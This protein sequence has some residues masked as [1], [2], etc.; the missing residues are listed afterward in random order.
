MALMTQLPRLRW[1]HLAA[2]AASNAAPMPVRPAG[3]ALLSLAYPEPLRGKL[4]GACGQRAEPLAD[5]Q[6][7]APALATD[8][9]LRELTLNRFG[10][11]LAH[12]GWRCAPSALRR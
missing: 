9:A 8:V 7:A 4:A 12:L 3:G 11:L 2:S 10:S 5:G 1:Q 6:P